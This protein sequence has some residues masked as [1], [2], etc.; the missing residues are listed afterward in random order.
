MIIKNNTYGNIKEYKKKSAELHNLYFS[1][2]KITKPTTAA[3]KE[4]KRKKDEA[5]K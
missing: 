2:I 3:S 1:S 4:V 5:K